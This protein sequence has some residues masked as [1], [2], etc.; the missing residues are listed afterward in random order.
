MSTVNRPKHIGRNISRIRELRGMKQGALADAIGTSQQTISS[1][2]TSETVD[3]DKLVQIA[4]ALGVTV[5]AIENFTEESVF[6]FFNNF[7]DNSANHGQVNGPFNSC[8]FN[9]LDKVVEL[10]ERLVQAEK[11]KVEYLE[12]LM[13]LK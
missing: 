12:K 4:K 7:Y 2:E 1:I 11:D 8:T 9:A 5:E 3:F 6:N 13:K 10:Y